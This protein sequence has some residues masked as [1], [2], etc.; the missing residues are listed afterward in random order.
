MQMRYK[1]HEIVGLPKT[2]KVYHTLDYLRPQGVELPPECLTQDFHP[3]EWDKEERGIIAFKYNE[4]ATGVEILHDMHLQT[5]SL[6][7]SEWA[8]EAD[9]LLYVDIVNAVLKKHPRSKLYAKY[10][11]LKGLTDLDANRMITERKR[12][13]KR[14]L[15]NKD[16]FTMEGLN[17]SF[18]LAVEHLRPA[19]SVDMQVF[20]LQ[21]M[22]TKMQWETP[23]E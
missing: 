8:V 17:S 9:V 15:I 13:L 19:S 1:Q 7:L 6:Y 21:R 14:T 4:S 3:L 22:F 5:L 10:D 20:E 16:H 18:T 23:E 11:I 12:Y 2:F